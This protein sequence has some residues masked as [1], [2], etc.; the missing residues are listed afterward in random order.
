MFQLLC[1]NQAG[2]NQTLVGEAL[3]NQ[4][5]YFLHMDEVKEQLNITYFTHIKKVTNYKQQQLNN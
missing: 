3:T 1:P 4:T 5:E 2:V